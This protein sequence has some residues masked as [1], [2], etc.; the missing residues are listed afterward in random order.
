MVRGPALILLIFSAS[1][2]LCQQQKPIPVIENGYVTRTTS[3]ADFDVN[4][5]H[6][7]PGK[8]IAF[9][10][11]ITLRESQTTRADPYLGQIVTIYG[12]LKKKKHQVIADNVL[13]PVQD[14]ATLSGFAI[15]DSILSPA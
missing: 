8:K 7:I 9:L 12:T 5:F 13:F 14:S 1:N 15:V 3:L 6:V 10:A 11:Q 2:V 4:G